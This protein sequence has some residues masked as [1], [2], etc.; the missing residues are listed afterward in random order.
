MRYDEFKKMMESGDLEQ[1]RPHLAFEMI[2]EDSPKQELYENCPHIVIQDMNAMPMVWAEF[3]DY[4]G[5][6]AKVPFTKKQCSR[7]SISPEELIQVVQDETAKK[8]EPLYEI[9]E[10]TDLKF[11]KELPEKD[12]EIPM[13]VATTNDMCYG[14]SVICTYDFFKQAARKIGGSYYVLP[15]SIHEILLVKENPDMLPNN[16]Q[17]LVGMVNYEKLD[18]TERLTDNAYHYDARK[19]LLETAT[20]YEAR[21]EK[22]RETK[23]DHSRRQSSSRNPERE[24][25]QEEEELER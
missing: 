13:F 11:G 9:H 3:D 8:M 12:K 16:F 1:I 25:P 19:D 23:K 5:I 18:E 7:F 10:F 20:E 2:A 4:P 6:M 17:Q 21:L 22:E 24:E 15:S 14:A